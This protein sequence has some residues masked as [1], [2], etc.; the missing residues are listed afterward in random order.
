MGI[1]A[2]DSAR[3]FH[4]TFLQK[5][6]FRRWMQIQGS[7]GK[8]FFARVTVFADSSVVAVKKA[9]RLAVNDENGIGNLVE[10]T[11][12]EGFRFGQGAHRRRDGSG[13][14][15]WNVRLR[16]TPRIGHKGLLISCPLGGGVRGWLPRTGVYTP[17]KRQMAMAI[18]CC[19]GLRF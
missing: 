18:V 1:F 3:R 7:H 14:T 13:D 4:N 15:G 11:A 6:M 2:A 16:P 10:K 9:L 19:R 8:K 12:I 17:K 5:C